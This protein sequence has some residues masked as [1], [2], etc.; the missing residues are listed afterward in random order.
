MKR[1]N[2]KQRVKSFKLKL[3]QLFTLLNFLKL[4]KLFALFTLILF[5]LP[6][7]A[8]AGIM[9]ER[10]A[11]M[12]MP[13]YSLGGA[14]G[15]TY[16]DDSRKS[17][18]T[19]THASKFSQN[20]SLGF[21]SY[22]FTPRFMYYSINTGFNKV[23]SKQ[24]GADITAKTYGFNTTFFSY[25]PFTFSLWASR[26]DGKDYDS[27]NYGLSMAY[28]RKVRVPKR[29]AVAPPVVDSDKSNAN[30][31]ANANTNANTNA[32]A[33]ANTNANINEN[34]SDN[35]NEN[36]N[37]NS[38]RKTA[39]KQTQRK[40]EGLF[41]SVVDTLPVTSYFNI[42]R[43]TNSARGVKSD[44]KN[45]ALR[46]S[47]YNLK[48][49]YFLNFDYEDWNNAGRSHKGYGSNLKTWTKMKWTFF[50]NFDNYFY[51]RKNDITTYNFNSSLTGS[52]KKWRYGIYA[53]YSRVSP[54]SARQYNINAN[55][56]NATP[57]LYKGVSLSYGLGAGFS[58]SSTSKSDY[59]GNGSISAF[60]R[61]GLNT[62]WNS[63]LGVT[64][65]K[66]GTT[67]SFQ[68]GIGYTFRPRKGH[69]VSIEIDPINNS[70]KTQTFK[71]QVSGWDYTVRT[72]YNF[73][74]VKNTGDRGASGTTAAGGAIRSQQKTIT[75]HRANLNLNVFL[76]RLT[77][78]SNA[79]YAYS[80]Q[81]NRT[82][83]WDN[84]IYT[85]VMGK[86]GV[87]LGTGFTMDMPEQGTKTKN[88][89]VYNQIRYRVSR[90]TMLN[91]NSRYT[92]VTPGNSTTL[93]IAPSIT[94]RWR[95]VFVELEASLK[96]DKNSTG[97]TTEKRIMLKVTRPFRIL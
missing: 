37:S 18:N 9:T 31:N 66:L 61:F 2:N 46:F 22:V 60:K 5:V 11:M 58:R 38:A 72:G 74:L 65:G 23:N 13:K 51:Y 67:F 54:G 94:W 80:P 10:D 27:T 34:D 35:D 40:S 43:S 55:M 56:S 14:I 7:D 1:L 19:T 39:P 48:T 6:Q 96:K 79:E 30:A 85:T 68:T 8:L 33:N 50:Q 4:F 82:F 87:T 16:E 26:T 90:V 78:A 28:T 21:H 70:L 91:L 84:T 25:K 88:S 89:N 47:G 63:S 45:A 73:G 29:R 17:G 42:D 62:D 95:L 81:I 69:M 3:L 71:P 83:K 64:G 97:K 75:T 32:N 15:L 36:E 41:S 52:T 57:Y 86:V 59:F 92:K 49:A 76:S 53:N 77:L 20:Y 24:S 93:E 44:W 12:R